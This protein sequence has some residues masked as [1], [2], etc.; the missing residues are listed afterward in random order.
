M[1]CCVFY[2]VRCGID[3]CRPNPWHGVLNF[4]TFPWAI[5]NVYVSLRLLPLRGLILYPHMRSRSFFME[6]EVILAR[7]FGT[8]SGS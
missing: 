1:L 8:A 2:W 7:L 4:D 6:C 3:C 5:I